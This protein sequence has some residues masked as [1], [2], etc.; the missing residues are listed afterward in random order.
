[1]NTCVDEF[2]EE[3][4][5]VSKVV[6]MAREVAQMA[7]VRKWDDVRLLSFDL[8]TAEFAY[9]EN[10]TVSITCTDQL[11]PTGGS[12]DLRF[13]RCEGLEGGNP[14]VD[15]EPFLRNIMRSG[16]LTICLNRVVE[17]LRNTLPIVVVLDEVRAEAIVHGD[18]VTSLAKAA[19]WYRLLYGDFK[20]ALDFRLMTGQRVAILD[21]SHSVFPPDPIW[22]RGKSKMQ[23]SHES[24]LL[25]HPIPD[26]KEIILDVLKA[27]V[28]GDVW[29]ID[30]GVMCT[31][32]AV[33]RVG[34]ALHERVLSKVKEG[35]SW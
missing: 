32:G 17:L 33:K 15:A 27:D 4:A 16:R 2:L 23:D 13:S 25:L 28:G 11:S 5:R 26:L 31:V 18:S 12:Y 34:K 21:A 14:H 10:Y 8:Q 9:A 20:H 22:S 19:A 29:S 30:V 24:G 7:K 1:V 6:V 35:G 3:W